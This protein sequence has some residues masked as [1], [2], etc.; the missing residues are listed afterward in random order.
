MHYALVEIDD[1]SYQQLPDDCD[2]SE[3]LEKAIRKYRDGEDNEAAGEES[4][5]Q[6]IEGSLM[7]DAR[8]LLDGKVSDDGKNVFRDAV[9]EVVG[10]DDAI[11]EDDVRKIVAAA[12]IDE[13]AIQRIV[14]DEIDR[15]EK[16]KAAQ[17]PELSPL[18]WALRVTEAAHFDAATIRN[19]L[20]TLPAGYYKNGREALEDAAA[21]ALVKWRILEALHATQKAEKDRPK[22]PEKT[23]RVRRAKLPDDFGE[24]AT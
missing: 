22:E 21:D 16:A 5:A 2:L 19:V 15:R 7:E 14:A 12:M 11:D 18:D 3:F 8:R 20:E 23:R 4:E 24:E 17:S 10:D 13:A 9:L 1:K 6:D